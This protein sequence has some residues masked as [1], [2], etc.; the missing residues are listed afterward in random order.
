[1]SYIRKE[2][3]L[4][5]GRNNIFYYHD[6]DGDLRS[7]P[8][9]VRVSGLHFV[10]RSSLHAGIRSTAE[11]LIFDPVLML[12]SSGFHHTIY[13]LRPYWIGWLDENCP[14]WGYPPVI[15]S[16]RVPPIYFPLY[17]YGK[18]FVDHVNHLLMGECYISD[19]ITD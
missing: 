4:I 12:G 8:C 10:G 2:H 19:S 1:M 18:L 7:F 16:D 5:I 9:I 6:E 14:G 11:Q 13:R 17:R 3:G 15:N